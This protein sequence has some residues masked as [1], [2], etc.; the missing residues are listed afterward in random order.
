VA[1]L[2]GADREKTQFSKISS[3]L[4]DWVKQIRGRNPDPTASIMS[5][6]SPVYRMLGFMRPISIDLEHARHILNK[7]TEISAEDIA[8]LPDLMT[9]PRAVLSRGSGLR[10]ILDARDAKGNPLLVALNPDKWPDG[11]KV[12]KVTEVSTLFGADDSAS[13]VLQAAW[14]N[15]LLYAPK[16]EVARLQALQSVES[17]S[18]KGGKAPHDTLGDD[19]RNTI[20]LSDA[21]LDKFKAGDKSWETAT[22]PIGINP[23]SP[24]ALK[25]VQFSKAAP[26]KSGNKVVDALPGAISRAWDGLKHLTSKGALNLSPVHEGHERD[27][28]GQDAPGAA[29]G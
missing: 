9:R 10:V 4:L 2:K 18:T 15:E 1:S 29:G 26:V 21:A 12:M 8:A 19:L 24:K 13:V 6:P 17:I 11:R 25:G 14:D 28:C 27:Q 22:V 3:K 7:H 23:A 16:G 5:V 20:V